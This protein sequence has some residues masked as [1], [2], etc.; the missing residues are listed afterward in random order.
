MSSFARE[1]IGRDATR[2]GTIGPAIFFAG[3]G[4]VS[5]LDR[6]VPLCP[7][8]LELE[9]AAPRGLG[10]DNAGACEGMWTP[11]PRRRGSMSAPALAATAVARTAES[12]RCARPRSLA[13]RLRTGQAAR[14]ERPFAPALRRM[15]AQV[16]APSCCSIGA[17]RGSLTERP[18]GL[19]LRG[20][21]GLKAH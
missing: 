19:H 16:S 10:R 8:A 3:Q 1:Q 6:R 2:R 5:T 17:E 14:R 11:G 15:L 7:T 13:L 21:L 4:D 9:Q 18:A 12:R 20:G